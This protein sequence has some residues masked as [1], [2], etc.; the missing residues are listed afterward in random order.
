MTTPGQVWSPRP[1]P[2]VKA[3]GIGNAGGS[4]YTDARHA[5]NARRLTG[6]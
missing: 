5:G 4:R 6:T 1:L 3:P 2:K